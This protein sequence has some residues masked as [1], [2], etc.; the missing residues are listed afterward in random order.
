[1]HTNIEFHLRCQ[2]DER[3][4]NFVIN[5]DAR[6]CRQKRFK[7]YLFNLDT[8]CSAPILC[9]NRLFYSASTKK[10]VLIDF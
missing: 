1:M 7:L 3:D 10:C 8:Y 2:W 6:Y 9:E 5:P 4:N